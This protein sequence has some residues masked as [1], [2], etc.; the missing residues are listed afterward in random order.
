MEYLIPA[1][2][3]V[4]VVGGFVTF[5]AI[6]ATRQSGP[7]ATAD[8]GAPGIGGDD[9]PLGDT[10]EHAGEQSE[11][12][13]TVDDPESRPETPQDP[14]EAAHVARPGEGEGRE[15]LEF[16]GRQPASERLADRDR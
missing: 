1:V 3:V 14:D 12:G 4:L 8:E 2:I 7:A 11:G 5:V 10:T 13:A 9:T 6:R 16:E 15:G